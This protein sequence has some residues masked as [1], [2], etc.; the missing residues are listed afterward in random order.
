MARGKRIDENLPVIKT[1]TEEGSI[2]N[3]L[4]TDNFGIEVQDNPVTYSCVEKKLANK[5][6]ED[7]K[8][9]IQYYKWTPFPSYCGT[10]EQAI[11]RILEK[12]VAQNLEIC[13]KLEMQAVV[14]KVIETYRE[15]SKSLDLSFHEDTIKI[16]SDIDRKY[17][18]VEEK[19][20]VLKNLEEELVSNSEKLMELIK[21]KRKIIVGNTEEKQHRYRLEK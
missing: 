21:E 14:D 19:L 13:T 7:G 3:I 5:T 8:S 17:R 11:K 9:V 15:F 2:P 16:M 6:S 20:K 4:I 18:E 10:L 1:N 12:C